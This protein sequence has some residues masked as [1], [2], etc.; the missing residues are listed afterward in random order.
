MLTEEKLLQ[1]V[2]SELREQ[3]RLAKEQVELAKEQ[4]ELVGEQSHLLRHVSETLSL[5]WGE[6][7]DTPVGFKITTTKL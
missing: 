5:I 2:L 3:T 7:D 1:L 6:I 4:V